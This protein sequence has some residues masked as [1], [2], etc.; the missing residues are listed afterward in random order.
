MLWAHGGGS[1][2]A[3]SVVNAAPALSAY[4]TRVAQAEAVLGL[5]TTFVNGA[6]TLPTAARAPT[7]L[8]SLLH[9]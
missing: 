8:P 7:V 1:A 3:V 2:S 9:R 5:L 6:A 4:T